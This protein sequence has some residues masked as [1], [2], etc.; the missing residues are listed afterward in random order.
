MSVYLL[1]GK[2]SALTMNVAGVVKDW[3]L[4]FISSF[5]FDAP[6][7]AIQL[8]GYLLAF[9]A[10]CYYN[11]AKFKVKRCRLNPVLKPVVKAPDIS[12]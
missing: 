12:S 3:I 9:L 5:I 6:I 10:V 7:S 11:Y 4:I 2:T 8:W 1:I